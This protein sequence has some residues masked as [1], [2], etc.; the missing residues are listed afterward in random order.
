MK[1]GVL[2]RNED[3]WCT[4]QL[5]ASLKKRGITPLCFSFHD[6]QAR[7]Q[8]K[9]EVKMRDIDLLRDLKAI[10]VRPIG[11]GS[12]EE[13]IFRLDVL[14]RLSRLGLYIL[15]SPAAIE[16][17]VDKYYA[18]TLLEEAGIPVPRTVV[19]E[20]AGSALTAFKELGCDVVVKPIFGSRGIG[21]ARVSDVDIAERIFR[22][23]EF[24]HQVIY[25]QEYLP[26]GN[27]DYRLFVVGNKIAA[28]MRRVSDCWKTNI[29]RGAKPVP[30]EPSS[31]IKSLALKSA[32]IV[33]C[34]VSGIDILE[35]EQGPFVIEINSQPGWRGLQSVTNINIADQIV[36]YLL[37]KVS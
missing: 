35:T 33:N 24:H 11:R 13:I 36:N 12:L 8:L 31:Q 7:I 37:T 28:S 9:P 18:L 29:S 25:I 16:R 21:S 22:S 1:I 5:I 6:L 27:Y 3:S 19:T 34:E 15:N 23:L 30:C 17:C 4:T 26:H 10:I 32:E 2:T 20:D 14:H